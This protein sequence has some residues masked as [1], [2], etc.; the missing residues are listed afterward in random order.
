MILIDLR[1]NYYEFLKSLCI[2]CGHDLRYHFS[3]FCPPLFSFPFSCLCSNDSKLYCL[4]RNL[5]FGGVWQ[6][7][8]VLFLKVRDH[9]QKGR[10]FLSSSRISRE[11]GAFLWSER[12]CPK[13][14]ERGVAYRHV[15]VTYPLALRLCLFRTRTHNFPACSLLLGKH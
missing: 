7:L 13:M 10:A 14:S 3:F 6:I 15:E 2:I 12:D 9:K 8:W 1:I 11:D 5:K 4:K